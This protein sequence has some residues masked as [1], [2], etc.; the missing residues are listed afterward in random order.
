MTQTK[1][2]GLDVHKETVAVA[3]ADATRD[4]E[5]RFYG[6]IPNAR[7]AIRRLFDRLSG[8]G[9]ELHFCYEAGGCGYEIYRQL[10]QPGASCDVIAPSMMPKKRGDR[11]KN[12]RRDAVALA[13]SLRAGELTAIWVPDESHEAMRD[14]VRARRQAKGDLVAARQMLLGFLLRHGRKFP[15]KTNWTRLHWR[16][17]GEQ[18]FGSPHQQ[19]VVGEGVRRIEKAQARCDRL[20]HMLQEAM[21]GWSPAPLVKALQALRGIGLVIAATLVTEIGDLTRFQTPRHLMGWL[22]LVP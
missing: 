16:W 3:I 13:R 12:D 15:G 17:L 20:D 4:G 2:I 6:T 10:R 7:E 14:L 11:I 5:V 1:F 9:V 21:E 22:G 8:S 18:A 19:F